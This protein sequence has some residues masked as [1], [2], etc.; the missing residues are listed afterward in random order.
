[1]YDKY[2]PTPRI[3]ID[4]VHNPDISVQYKDLYTE[5]T[6]GDLLDPYLDIYSKGKMFDMDELSQ[7][8]YLLVPEPKAGSPVHHRLEPIN[9]ALK[10][11]FDKRIAETRW[12]F[13]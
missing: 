2:G 1:M 8:I 13:V 6:K 11:K 12:R 4:F 10:T 7:T 9:R 3:C 5:A